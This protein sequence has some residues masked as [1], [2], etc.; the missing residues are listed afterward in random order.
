MKFTDGYWKVREGYRPHHPR[1][2]YETET[3]G[4]SVTLYGP[5]MRVRDR[6][7]TLNQT[8]LTV[9]L[10]PVAE[11]VVAVRVSHFT[12]GVSR[13]PTFATA[14]DDGV[15]ATVRDTE[16]AVTLSSG[17]LSVV[18]KKGSGWDLSF[19]GD[20]VPLTRSTD[21]SVGYVVTED[22]SS[23]VHEQ[24]V[25]GVGTRVYGLGERFGPLVKNGQAIDIWNE[26]GGTSSEQA[27]KNVP[28]F[29][30]NRGY[31]VFV[32]DPGPVSFEVASEKVS[33]VQFSVPGEELEYFVVYGPSPKTILERYTALTGRPALPPRWS[34]GLW[35]TTSFT[36][37]YD[38]DTVSS[39]LDGMAEREI[40]V[41]VF[42]FDTFWMHDFSWCDFRWDTSVFP[43]PEGLVRRLKDR[44]V[45]VSLWINPY[46]AQRSA[47]F[48]EAAEHGYLLRRPNGDVWQIDQWQPG[49]GIVDFTNPAAREWF[50]S[51]L[52]PLLRMGVDSFKTDFGERI[53]VDV[54]Y[55]DG[56]DPVRMHNYFAHL[57]NQTVFD[58]LR[59]VR[60]EGEAVVFARSATAGGQQFPV[61]WGGDCESTFESMAE[62]LRGGLSLGL[63]GFGF[64]SHDIGG[65]EGT[66][67]PSV[68]KRWVAFGL[69][70]SHSRLHGSTSYRVPWLIDD[71]SVDVLR[72]FVR[73]KAL[74]MPYLFA[75]AIDATRSGVPV[76]RALMVEFP[77]DPAAETAEEQYM[78]GDAL[79][80]APVFSEA[81]DVTFYLPEGR[82]TS[83][84]SGEVV[85]GGRW[86]SERHDVMSVPLY[87]RDGAVVAHGH[88]EDRVVYDYDDEVELRVYLPVGSEQRGTRRVEVHGDNGVV[89]ASFEVEIGA[90]SVVARRTAGSR[91]WRLSLVEGPDMP[92]TRSV[93]ADADSARIGRT[94]R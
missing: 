55:H 69:L 5:T 82:W 60:G 58:L 88:R 56:S 31:G 9:R 51:Q 86:V 93:S 65:F 52:R 30:T 26:D 4:R 67:A 42:H 89:S 74:L 18:A 71:E 39:F 80:V 40:P 44:G 27:Y 14:E 81:G 20:G 28:F 23:Y 11:G 29:L 36:T 87:V 13:G 59:E 37:S 70:S 19:A 33:R 90:E 46:I 92:Q 32:N 2:I 85:V 66:P 94:V 10:R 49:M 72:R 68:Y 3:D 84:F 43:D 79:L 83:Y 6:G 7:D 22:G 16:E 91:G 57:Y 63:C 17:G 78:L 34:F 15:P 64:W 50:R 8:M 35:L 12:G 48:S 76:M 75:A 73:L 62:S 77:G 47:L 38:E 45:R 54:V 24:L 1:E 41:D 25:L 61:H 53:P 21:K